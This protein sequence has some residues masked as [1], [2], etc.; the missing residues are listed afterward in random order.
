MSE[1]VH[2]LLLATFDPSSMLQY[3]LRVVFMH[4]GLY[5]RKHLYSYVH[6]KS[7]WWKI[8]DSLIEK[9]NNYQHTSI[10]HLLRN[11]ISP[12]PIALQ[13]S[14]EAVLNDHTGLHL[15]AGPYLLFYSRALPENVDPAPSLPW[16][17][18]IKVGVEWFLVAS[19]YLPPQLA[20][21]AY[22][23]TP[24]GRRESSQQR[25]PLTAPAR[26]RERYHDPGRLP[27]WLTPRPIHAQGCGGGCAL[28]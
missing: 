25:I 5:G 17:D 16:P 2:Y 12:H 13:V 6:D 9:V 24:T 7:F 27:A 11:L 28:E 18:D 14:E 26:A 3:D 10:G 22:R 4:D 15:G 19:C 20:I 23:L 8:A 1:Y 21:V